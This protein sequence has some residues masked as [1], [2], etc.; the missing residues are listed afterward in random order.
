MYM[1]NLFNQKEEID[2]IRFEAFTE[3]DKFQPSDIKNLKF[4]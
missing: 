3:Y 2:L 4:H 1:N